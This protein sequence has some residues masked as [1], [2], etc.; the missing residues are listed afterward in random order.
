MGYFDDPTPGDDLSRL[1]DPELFDPELYTPDIRLWRPE[2]SARDRAFLNAM[3]RGPKPDN[4][5]MRRP[6]SDPTD[7]APRS[8]GAPAATVPDEW[9]VTGPRQA[10]SGAAAA[11]PSRKGNGPFMVEEP[12]AFGQGQAV[13]GDEPMPFQGLKPEAKSDYLA[14]LKDPNSTAADIL[15]VARRWRFQISPAEVE[16]FVRERKK[17][18]PIGSIRYRHKAKPLIDPGDGAEGAFVRGVGDPIN[19]LD[20]LG[21][22]V[23]A[24][25][26]TDGRESIFNSDRRFGD[27]LWS[28]IDLNRAILAFDERN[29]PWTRTG[30]QIAGS[31]LLPGGSTRGVGL[32]AGRM[33]L[34][35]GA[36]MAEAR[37]AARSA[38]LRRMTAVGGAEGAVAGF[39]AGEG[40]VV[41]RLPDA[42]AGGATGAVADRLVGKAGQF[43]ADL[44]G[45]ARRS[46]PEVD[47]ADL[48]RGSRR[49]GA[50]EDMPSASDGQAGADAIGNTRQSPP[51]RG[52]RDMPSAPIDTP[53]ADRAGRSPSV[54]IEDKRTIIRNPAP[55]TIR[56]LSDHLGVDLR[57]MRRSDGALVLPRRDGERVRD[58]IADLYAAPDEGAPM[59]RVPRGMDERGPFSPDALAPTMPRI[60]LENG[61]TIIHG[62][63]RETIRGIEA[64]LPG[65]VRALPRRDGGFMLPGRYAEDARIA[66]DLI[67]AERPGLPANLIGREEDR[68]RIPRLFDP[69]DIAMGALPQPGDILPFYSAGQSDNADDGRKPRRYDQGWSETGTIGSSR[70]SDAT[71]PNDLDGPERESRDE[72]ED[73][74]GEGEYTTFYH[75]T[76]T[77]HAAN[78]RAWGVSLKGLRENTDFGRG[79]YMTKSFE[80]A[81]ESGRRVAKAQGRGLDVVEFRVP[82]AELNQLRHKRFEAPDAEW[83]DFVGRQRDQK[84]RPGLAPEWDMI[85][86]P[87]YQTMERGV[88]QSFTDRSDQTSIHTRRAVDLF[89]RYMVRE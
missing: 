56:R 51:G 82:N 67:G 84:K 43:G 33:A 21:G 36:T 9:V 37:L 46:L 5:V 54:T 29:H 58:G 47:I 27:I 39:G 1:Y 14:V 69:V 63:D 74:E 40:D 8:P 25:G 24:L 23:D 31:V 80:E 70:A 42:L 20:E 48:L 52:A 49:G 12:A 10:A 57:P 50:A 22:V 68:I 15:G 76:A 60:S 71:L 18:H 11:R 41:D 73:E 53:M 72:T 88:M 35:R 19:M 45:A 55:D 75:G 2:M 7:G 64:Y 32:A 62:A 89:N 77:N 86:G 30:G 87:M 85:T 34:A 61:R 38:V 28:N 59:L 78:I 3:S 13:F 4:M 26:G 16:T 66:A 81:R 65:G 83:R 79:F 44:I 17:G 6:P